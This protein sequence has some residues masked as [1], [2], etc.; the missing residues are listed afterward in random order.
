MESTIKRWDVIYSTDHS[1]IGIKGKVYGDSRFPNGSV[2]TTSS[3]AEWQPGDDIDDP[4]VTIV[5]KTGSTYHLVNPDPFAVS[6]LLWH[7]HEQQDYHLD[8]LKRTKI[9]GE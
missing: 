4:M 3:V 7:L 1:E 2:I 8:E 9:K 5:T 6:K